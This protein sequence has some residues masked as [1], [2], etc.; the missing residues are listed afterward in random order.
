MVDKPNP[1]SPQS[2]PNPTEKNKLDKI[3][4]GFHFKGEHTFAGLKFNE[5][6]WNKLMNT[7]LS[8]LSEYINKTFQK[9]TA[10]MKQDWKRSR[11]EDPDS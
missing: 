8:T 5:G 2:G 7:C 4:G 3:P 6:E 9:M 1:I 10:K 11:G